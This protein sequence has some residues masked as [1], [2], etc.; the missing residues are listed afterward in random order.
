MSVTGAMIAEMKLVELTVRYGKYVIVDE[1]NG[2]TGKGGR[3]CWYRR[4]GGGRH[5]GWRYKN[6]GNRIREG[7]TVTLQAAKKDTAD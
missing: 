5:I 6:K 4:I 7:D 2:W 3:A 1:G